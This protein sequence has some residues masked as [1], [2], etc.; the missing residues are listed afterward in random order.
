[1][2]ALSFDNH[3]AARRII[4]AALEIDQIDHSTQYATVRYNGR[5]FATISRARVYSKGKAWAVH[6][7]TGALLFEANFAIEFANDA[8][9]RRLVSIIQER[10]KLEI[11]T[12]AAAIGPHDLAA[13]L[14]QLAS[15]AAAPAT[16][17]CTYAE[18]TEYEQREVTARG[19]S[20]A[21]GTRYEVKGRYDQ[22]AGELALVRFI[23][24]APVNPARAALTRAVNASIAAGN[25]VFEN[26]PAAPAP[27]YLELN[28]K[29][30]ARSESDFVESLFHAGGTCAGFFKV[31]AH[32][33]ELQN[34]KG[35]KIAVIN[36]HAVLCCATRRD[37]GRFWYSHATV[38]EIGLFSSYGQQRAELT[39]A[40]EKYC[41]GYILS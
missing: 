9:R 8:F 39:G 6:D 34:M 24:A 30:F 19:F 26:M 11:E 32:E 38:K 31:R 29:R 22:D 7:V 41:G 4:S 40:M 16:S 17:I 15:A 28:G 37:D 5:A 10:E 27:E 33:I 2:I 25:P 35:E 18:L 14:I 1:M 20:R 21:A 12:S 13:E 23:S 3:L 36:R